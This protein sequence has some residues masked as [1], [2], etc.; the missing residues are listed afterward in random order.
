MIKARPVAGDRAAGERFPRGA[1]PFIWRKHLDF[2]A[3]HDIHSIKR[4]IDAYRGGGRSRSL[5]HNVKLGRG[6]IREIE[7]FAQTQ[8]LILG[9]RD[10]RAAPPP[11]L[12]GAAP[13]WPP[14]AG[15]TPAAADELIDALRLP[16]PGRAPPADGGRP[17]DPHACPSDAAG[18]ARLAAFLGYPRRRGLRSRAAAPRCAG[19][20]PLRRLFEEAPSLA[21]PGGNLVFT[22]TDDDP[23]D[24]G[25]P[26][27]A[28]LRR[29][30]GG[31]G[32]GARLASRPHPRH[33]QPR[34]RELLTELMPGTAARF[35][36]T[37][38]PRHGAAALRPVP[39]AA[40]RPACSCSRCSRPT[41]RCSTLVADIMGAA[42]ALADH[43]ARRPALLDG[44]VPGFLR[45]AARPRRTGGRAGRAAGRC[46]PTSRT[47]ST[48]RAAGP[49]SGASRSACSS[50]SARS[51]AAR[52][53]PRS[54]TSP[55][56]RSPRC[57][58]A[59]ER[60]FAQRARPVAG[61]QRWRCWRWASSAAAR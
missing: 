34:A 47:C 38:R 6:G 26:G 40:C 10:P 52:P 14:P 11:D 41:R 39:V 58:R 61:R 35:G 33:A 59:V 55:R 24:A 32:D 1:T 56:R 18:I 25:D 8:Q 36:G 3:I 27:A 57:C 7:F 22:G 37:A 60:S 21:G 31:R 46:S 42:P 49:T 17:A 19:R 12:R 30:G 53:A 45:P 2:A 48:W 4:Q 16:A 20:E 5:G 9:G 54:P 50:S 15:S 43:L 51:T 13:R 28:G 29:S 23:G 44:A